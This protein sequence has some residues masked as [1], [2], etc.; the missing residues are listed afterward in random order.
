MSFLQKHTTS[1]EHTRERAWAMSAVRK[2]QRIVKK[3]EKEHAEIVYGFTNLPRKR[4]HAEYLLE[5]N[6]KH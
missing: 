4:A 2:I 5:L 1:D 3:G 6:Q